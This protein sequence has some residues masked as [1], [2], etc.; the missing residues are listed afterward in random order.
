MTT[1]LSIHGMRMSR[2]TGVRAIMEDIR[3]TLAAS[4]SEPWINLSPGNPVVLPEVE[5]MWRAHARTVADSNEFGE[6]VCRYGESQG[7]SPLVD[8]VVDLFNSKYDWGITRANVLITPGSQSLLF[9]AAN[10]FCGYDAA[11]RLRK[12]LLPLSPDYTGYDGICLSE[13]ALVSV[14]PDIEIIDAHTFKY[15]VDF[16]RLRIEDDIGAVMF[17]RPCNPS[18]NVIRTDEV[19]RIVA[20]ARARDVPVIIDA[21][22]GPPFP[23]LAFAQIEPFRGDNVVYSMSMSKTGLPG[24][25]IGIAIGPSRYLDVMRAFLTNAVLHSSRF[26]QA[27][28]ARAIASGEL[29]RVSQ[30]VIGPY[31]RKKFELMHRLMTESMPH[32][33]WYLHKF[34]G[35]LFAWLWLKDLPISDLELYEEIKRE[36]VFVVPGSFFFPGTDGTWKHRAECLRISLTATDEELTQ[37]VAAIARVARRLYAGHT[38]TVRTA[39]G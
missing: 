11:G 1:E 38:G 4:P 17:S 5:A 28:A 6:V 24:E 15:G 16:D 12:L 34:E 2:L 18:G 33:D 14:P 27:I 9:A 8:A 19:E 29:V 30:A 21:A 10:C 20:L 39:A 37:G 35:A 3:Q 25:R 36:R 26:G 13:E 32:I 22:Y 23:H 31:Y 7:Y